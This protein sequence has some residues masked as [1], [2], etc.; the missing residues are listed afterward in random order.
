[1]T[2]RSKVH[3]ATTGPFIIIANLLI[4]FVFCTLL[5]FVSI[6]LEDWP[7]A[8]VVGAVCGILFIAGVT[9]GF[10]DRYRIMWI[11]AWHSVAVM[12]FQIIALLIRWDYWLSV[13]RTHAYSKY[14]DE[15]YD[16]GAWI[17]ISIIAIIGGLLAIQCYSVHT[18][19]NRFRTSGK[20]RYN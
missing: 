20:S 8:G 19:N 15:S 2:K 4:T 3:V 5:F 17:P 12:L 11:L 10:G 18:R 7:V 14:Y 9:K 16:V 6:F 1:M 13:Y